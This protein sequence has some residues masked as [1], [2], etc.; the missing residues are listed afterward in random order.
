MGPHSYDA[1]ISPTGFFWAT[2]VPDRSVRVDL[3]AGTASLHAENIC[4]FDAFTVAN[5]LTASRPMGNLVKG[6]INSLRLEWSGVTRRVT[7]F[8][9]STDKFRGDFVE[10]SARIEVTATTPL[11]TGHGFRFVSDHAAT[12]VSHFA[13]IGEE[14]NGTFF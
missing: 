14:H 12:S 9:D 2:Q 3:N 5:S 13:Q 1:G 6:I 10:N 4:V 11:S 8:A 7:G